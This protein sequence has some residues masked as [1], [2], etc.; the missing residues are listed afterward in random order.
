MSLPEIPAPTMITDGLSDFETVV[1]LP[2]HGVR[3]SRSRVSIGEHA[4]VGI[5]ET[6]LGPLVALLT[7]LIKTKFCEN[8]LEIKRVF[9]ECFSWVF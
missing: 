1:D 4:I 5:N 3:R 6:L 7:Q 9:N 8:K 2:R